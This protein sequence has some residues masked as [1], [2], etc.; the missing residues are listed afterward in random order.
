MTDTFGAFMRIGISINQKAM[1][2]HMIVLPKLPS[3]RQTNITG[4]HR[5]NFVNP[6]FTTAAE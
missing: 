3:F 2:H 6:A 1:R 5:A 4:I